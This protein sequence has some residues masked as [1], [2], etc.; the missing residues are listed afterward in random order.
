M[1]IMGNLY[2]YFSA[3]DDTAALALFEAGPQDDDFGT[4]GLK[5]ADPYDLLGDVQA[6][7]TGCSPETAED[8]PRFGQLLSDPHNEGKW[9]VTL[10]HE[11]RDALAQTDPEQLRRTASALVHGEDT[12]P[13]WG[14]DLLADFLE[15]LAALS[16]QAYKQQQSLYCLISL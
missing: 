11:V 9:L 14:E 1:A 4:L 8:N 13:G 3:A 6:Q 12:A 2:S 10:T 7:L 5:G 16:R 15:R